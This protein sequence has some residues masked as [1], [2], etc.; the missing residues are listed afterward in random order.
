MAEKFL[1]R[2][3]ELWADQHQQDIEVTITGGKNGK[4]HTDLLERGDRASGSA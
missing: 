2:L 4:E 3:A 1:Q